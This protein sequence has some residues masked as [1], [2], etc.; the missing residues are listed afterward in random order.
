VSDAA[1]LVT[2]GTSRGQ[3]LIRE[4]GATRAIA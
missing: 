3:F 2:F 4:D 1:N